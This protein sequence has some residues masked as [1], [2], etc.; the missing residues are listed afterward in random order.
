MRV[1]GIDDRLT[2]ELVR[3][4]LTATQA[5]RII[6][7]GSAASGTMTPDSDLDLLVV[8]PNP[9]DTREESVKLRRALDDVGYPVDVMVISKQRFEETKNVFGGIAYPAH[10]YGRVLYEAA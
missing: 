1:M 4:I 7:F 3:R 10:K 5:D 6:L 2:R 9:E 8:E